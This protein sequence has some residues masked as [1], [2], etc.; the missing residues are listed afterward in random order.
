MRIQYILLLA[1]L[2]ADKLAAAQS[3]KYFETKHLAD[4]LTFKN[5]YSLAGNAYTDLLVCCRDYFTT[6]D[7]LDG[8]TVYAKLGEVDKAF[9]FLESLASKKH[10]NYPDYFVHQQKWAALENDKRWK[11]FI[12]QVKLNL[13]KDIKYYNLKLK[14]ELEVIYINDQKYRLPLDSMINQYGADSEEVDELWRK[15]AI[16]DRLNL[17][18]VRS[19]LD[20][21]GW[22]GPKKVGSKAAFALYIVIHHADDYPKLQVKYAKMFKKAILDGTSDGKDNYAF[23]QDRI[24][25]NLNRPQI[26]GTQLKRCKNGN[27]APF[28]IQDSIHVDQRRQEV[29]LEPLKYY[30]R[31]INQMSGS[32]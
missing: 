4:S 12:T 22:L 32:H 6:N 1:L 2:L 8:A 7:Y 9:S 29:G 26:Y 23:L 27:F 24:L 10:Y 30:V 21:F 20:T 15:M 25:L 11:P 28:P 19:I 17:K 5:E 14:S 18:K 31:L 13:Q 16:A 3:L